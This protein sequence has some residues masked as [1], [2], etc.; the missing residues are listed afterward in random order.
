VPKHAGAKKIAAVLIGY[1]NLE[2]DAFMLDG[3]SL[4]IEV[5]DIY[6]ITILSHRGDVVNLI[7]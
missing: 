2:A 3:Q 1:W 4:T 5:D 6:F 7:T